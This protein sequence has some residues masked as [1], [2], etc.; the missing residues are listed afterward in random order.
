MQR[1]IRT[2]ACVGDRLYSPILDFCLN[3]A[4]FMRHFMAEMYGETPGPT[5]SFA[6]PPIHCHQTMLVPFNMQFRNVI[7]GIKPIGI[8]IGFLDL[9]L[10]DLHPENLPIENSSEAMIRLSSRLISPIFL[11]FYEQ[12][13]G[14][15]KDKYNR[16]EKTWPEIFRFG[17]VIRNAISHQ[18]MISWD[19]DK[20]SPV[21]WR[22]LRYS[23]ADNKKEIIGFDLSM[24]DIVFLM[25]DMS[26]ELDRLGCP[27]DL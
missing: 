15:W 16:D 2:F 9:K 3:Y 11:M 22:G 21:S 13:S 24:A 6:A 26:D 1:T 25:I 7:G 8:E 27:V 19:N 12:Y 18:M 23:S 4:M 14:W 20:I 5:S 17:R 10:T